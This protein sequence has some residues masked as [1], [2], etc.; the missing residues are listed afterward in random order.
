MSSVAVVPNGTEIDSP[1]YV[2]LVERY[3]LYARQTAENIIGL[4]ETL[5]IA[6]KEL[7][8]FDLH[9]FCRDV[10]LE[11]KGPTFRKLMTIGEKVARF[12]PFVDRMP[13]A[14]TTVYKLAS[15]ENHEFDRVTESALF[16]PLMTAGDVNL[17]VNGKPETKEESHRDLMIDLSGLERSA[18]IELY[19]KVKALEEKFKFRLT[20]S[21][22]LKSVTNNAVTAAA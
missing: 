15:L 8:D 10:G 22:E 4:A 2:K 11:Y 19:R 12:Q 13:N 21:A 16:T 7:G 1:H 17:V 3:R 5:V 6:K 9:R 14:W 20:L 18:K